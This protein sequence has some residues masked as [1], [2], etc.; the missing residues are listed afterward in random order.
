MCQD[1]ANLRLQQKT[2]RRGRRGRSPETIDLRQGTWCTQDQATTSTLLSLR[3]VPSSPL[4]KSHSSIRLSAGRS[5]VQ[6]FM[7]PRN[8]RLSLGTACARSLSMGTVKAHLV[9]ENMKTH[10]SFT[11]SSF[12]GRRW[13]RIIAY[14]A[15]SYTPAVT[16]SRTLGGT[17]CKTLLET[18]T[19][20]ESPISV[21][22]G[23]S[24]SRV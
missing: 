23:M 4:V 16:R 2:R 19:R 17:Q 22:E 1:P 11:T 10:E 18:L 21:L 24:V 20:W 6:V 13:G 3:L 7:T 15:T 5:Q 14:R 8:P 9:Q 12:L